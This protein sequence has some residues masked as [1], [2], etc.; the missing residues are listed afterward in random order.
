MEITADQ[1]LLRDAIP[2]IQDH[3]SALKSQ[4]IP[5]GLHTFG[6][7]PPA[8]QVAGVLAESMTGR[9]AETYGAP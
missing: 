6:R 3:V 4:N 8:E 5:Y 7:V 2:K 9:I 1:S